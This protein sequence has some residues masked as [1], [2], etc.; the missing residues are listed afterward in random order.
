[1]KTLSAILFFV[2]LS[3]VIPA[4]ASACITFSDCQIG[5]RCVKRSGNLYGVCKGGMSPGNAHD[6]HPVYDPLDPDGTYGD[7]CTYD[8]NCGVNSKC[9]KRRI[10]STGTCVKR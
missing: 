2:I 9:M 7:T 5:S 6:K 8:S 3:F 4:T 1:M 10:A